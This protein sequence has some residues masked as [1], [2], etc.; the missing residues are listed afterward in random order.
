MPLGRGGAGRAPD[1]DGEEG[2]GL[3]ARTPLPKLKRNPEGMPPETQDGGRPFDLWRM[4]PLWRSFPEPH[5]ANGKRS[6]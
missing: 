2:C 1:R 4:L 5:P 6:G 3:M